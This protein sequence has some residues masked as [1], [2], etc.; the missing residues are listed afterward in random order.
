MVKMFHKA[1]KKFLKEIQKNEDTVTK[2][3]VNAIKVKDICYKSFIDTCNRSFDLFVAKNVDVFENVDL[4]NSD[5]L[6]LSNILT[7]NVSSELYW[8]SLHKLYVYAFYDTHN[9]S[10]V[11]DFLPRFGKSTELPSY[12]ADEWKRLAKV[13]SQIY[14]AAAVSSSLPP[15]SSPHQNHSLI[16]NLAK[17]IAGDLQ[18]NNQLSS[19]MKSGKNPNEIIMNLMQ[20]KDNDSM[21]NLFST[22]SEKITEKLESKEFDE[23]QIMNEASSMISQMDNNPLLMNMMKNLMPMNTEKK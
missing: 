18:N 8:K 11:E 22:V 2:D 3:V 21:N 9:K 16:H 4:F 1:L 7:D 14:G 12:I 13:Y 5:Q 15:S 19:L 23:A 17:E 6:S 20:G 10:D